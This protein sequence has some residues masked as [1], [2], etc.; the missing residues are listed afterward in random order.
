MAFG[1]GIMGARSLPRLAL[2]MV[3][4]FVIT[5]AG[6][7]AAPAELLE[8]CMKAEV[9]AMLRQVGIDPRIRTREDA[10]LLAHTLCQAVA[11]TC[12]AEPAGDPCRASMARYGLGQ[13]GYAPPPG[14]GRELFDAAYR[15]DVAAVQRYL[16][17]GADPDYRN[18]G[19][20]TPLMIAAAERHLDAVILLLQAKADPNRR[21]AYGRTALMFASRYGQLAIV[22]RLLAAGADPNVVPADATGWTALVSAATEGHAA[23]VRALLDKGAD[24]SIRTREGL[25]PLDVARASGHLEVAG[26]LE[27]AMRTGS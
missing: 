20:W 11:R 9:P 7:G 10:G 19:G 1:R 27:A 3:L 17:E 21:N 24:P 12:V 25:T 14:H 2:E 13:P 22:E 23:V 5:T 6:A 26:L 8:A 4:T 18:P 16:S 15:G